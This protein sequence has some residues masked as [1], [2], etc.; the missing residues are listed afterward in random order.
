MTHNELFLKRKKGIIASAAR[1]AVDPNARPA[2]HGNGRPEIDLIQ[3]G[4]AEIERVYGGSRQTATMTSAVTS[5][6][7]AARAA[8]ARRRTTA[9]RH[10]RRAPG[11]RARRGELTGDQSNGGRST[12]GDGDEEKAAEIFGLTTTAMLRGS[13]AT[14]K[15]RTRTAT[16]WRPRRRPSRA[17]AT[18]GATA[19]HG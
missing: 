14:A 5:P 3:N 4:T 17:M 16:T 11:R 10:E 15:R 1:V 12:D 18:T 8:Q 13:T 2:V 7:A 6:P 9:L 19:A